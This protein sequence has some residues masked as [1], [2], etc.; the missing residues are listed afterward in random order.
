VI[1]AGRRLRAKDSYVPQIVEFHAL[2]LDERGDVIPEAARRA[3]AARIDIGFYREDLFNSPSLIALLGEESRFDIVNCIGLT[4][5][6]DLPDV[7]RLTSFFHERLIDLGGTLIVD[8]FS[9]H[10]FSALGKKLEMNTRYHPQDEFVRTIESTGFLLREA[11]PTR[12][13]V[14]TVYVFVSV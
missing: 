5:W 3:A 11:R 10:R 14:N 9:W 12:N 7:Q 2:D 4:A 13:R 6:L 8:N 1:T